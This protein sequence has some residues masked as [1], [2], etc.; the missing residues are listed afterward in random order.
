VTI[1]GREL[2]R[3]ANAGD[4]R[5]IKVLEPWR[6]ELAKRRKHKRARKRK[7]RLRQFREEGRL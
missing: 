7:R 4:R 3:R 1:D 5:A 6:R 2:E